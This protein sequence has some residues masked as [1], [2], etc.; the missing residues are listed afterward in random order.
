MFQH[1]CM[2]TRV[3]RSL[4]DFA[5]HR[6]DIELTCRCGHYAVLPRGPVL[7]R[8]RRKGWSMSLEGAAWL[9]S[10]HAYFR[11][12]KCGQRPVKIGMG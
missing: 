12:S 4:H 7:A 9:P 2:G 6:A 1:T 3:V 11:C 10:A 5:R 8:F